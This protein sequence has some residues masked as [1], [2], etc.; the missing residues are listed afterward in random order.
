M[1]KARESKR[2][3]LEQAREAR[4]VRKVGLE[5]ARDARRDELDQKRLELEEKKMKSESKRLTLEMV[6]KSQPALTFE[7][8]KDLIAMVEKE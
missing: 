6:L 2:L 5:E 3:D 4:E 7:Q 8:I 1:E